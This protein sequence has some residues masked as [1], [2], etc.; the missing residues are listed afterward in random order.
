[1]TTRLRSLRGA[2]AT[3]ALLA[4][5]APTPTPTPAQQITERDYARAEQFLP[6]NAA[7]LISGDQ[8][9]P[10]FF[11]GDRFWFRSRTPSG[12]Q[13]VVVDPAAPSRGPAFDH[14]RLA[15]ALSL[16][17]D[18]AYEGR[19]LPFT[20]FD[21][22]NGG[23]S[24]R[25]QVADSVQWTCDVRAYTCAGPSD[26]PAPS[27]AERSSPDGRWIAFTRD[28]NLWVR[29]ADTG[30]EIQLSRDGEADFGYGAV[31]EGCCR[32]ITSRR[33][34]TERSP[35]LQWSP[36]SRR[37]ATHRY[38]EREV[39][40]FHLIEAADG[41]PILHS[42]AYA[43]PGDSIIPTSELWIF[44]VEGRAGVR[45]DVDP[46][47]GNFT[48]GDTTYADLQW[49][50]DGRSVFYTHRS[51]DFKSTKLFRVDAATGTATEL[52]DETGPTY[53]EL[54]QFT[55]LPPAWRV[56][57]DGSE[58]LWWSERDG[59]GH[60]YLY[61]GDGTLKNRVTSGPWLVT[62]LI[63]VDEAS[64]SVYFTAVGREEGRHPYFIH[65]YSAGLDGSEPRLLTPEDAVHQI[66]VS[67]SGRYFIDSYST[68]ETPPTAVV[69]GRDGRVAQTVETSDLSRLKEAGWI[70]PV[71]FQ[72]RGRDGVTSVYGLLWFPS[73]FDPAKSYPVVD[74]IYPGPQVG[75]VTRYDFS[76]AGRGN[77]RALAELGFIVFAVDAF[78]TPLRSKA[79]HDGYYGNMGDNGLPDH[80]SALKELA[81]RY[82]QIDLARVG[83]FGHS[84]GGFSST[85]AILR[86]PDFFQGC[87][88][89]R[90]Q[91]RQPRLSL[92]V[93]GEVPGTAR[94]QR[95][96]NRQ[97]RQ[98]GQPEPGREP[99]REAAAA[100]RNARRQRA[101]QHDHPRHRGADRAQQ[102]LRHVRASEPEPRVRERALCAAQNVGLLRRAPAGQTAAG[103][104]QDHRPR[105]LIRP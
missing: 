16:A 80:I 33:A 61:D 76:A 101:P 52:L 66:T 38:D 77:G 71:P 85:D 11:D 48:R 99:E 2:A 13:F 56:L 97:L 104:V 46:Q 20:E 25:F 34:N 24:V 88:V 62:E 4:T 82:S 15:A 75:A 39:E 8:V 40:R 72:A 83:I 57:G 35:V 93:G 70:P 65:L 51:R 44:D 32:E 36:D 64:R 28:E 14:D 18:T 92:P 59:F 29:D 89:G 1:M 27:A 26:E 43:L 96:R 102:G 68:P 87:G 12:H 73:N 94:R 67:P 19:D 69:R 60:L 7:K 63:A 30:D 22:V 78:G 10:E 86:H 37:I 6:W 100:L 98:P 74:Y 105:G 79:F 41:R 9:A 49:T 95:G 55:A 81:G 47:P 53:V 91:P 5:V 21:F 23:G 42:W 54:N 84:G 58:F 103:P 50:A 45:A 31:P 17:A 90:G 3:L